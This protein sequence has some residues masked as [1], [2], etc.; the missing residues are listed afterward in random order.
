MV[1]EDAV[2]VY[3]QLIMK[4]IDLLAK[5][6]EEHLRNKQNKPPKRPKIRQGSLS[7]DNFNKLMKKGVDF[8]FIP[9]PKERAWE[10]ARTLEG[11]GGSFFKADDRESANS[12]FAV[13]ANQLEMVQTAVKQTLS[14]LMKEH[15]EAISVKEGVNRIAPEDISLVSDVMRSYDIPLYTFKG[16]DG[17]YTNI[18]PTGSD[19]QYQEA[20]SRVTELKAQLENIDVRTFEMNGLLEMPEYVAKVIPEE[21][22]KDIY[23]VVQ[24]K[25]LDVRFTHNN[26]DTVILYPS[27]QKARVEDAIK[28][29]KQCADEIGKFDIT[30]NDNSISID[31]ETL[32]KGEDEREYFVKVPN[33]HG[34]DYLR[35]DKG[36]VS[37]INSGKTLTTKLEPKALYPIFNSRGDF[38]AQRATFTETSRRS[39]GITTGMQST[40]RRRLMITNTICSSG[41]HTDSCRDD[42]EKRTSYPHMSTWTKHNHICT[43]HSSR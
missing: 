23:A 6:G 12:L 33:T 4:F 14:N 35:L 24:A 32:L 13:P 41:K 38:V 30:V 10:I 2:S 34:M 39:R 29:C 8:K 40:S 18:V 17:M 43:F 3:T 11:L 19:G 7:K 1:G 27:W 36:I 21:E 42:T 26:D 37:E 15:P 25:G 22:S 28:E 20:M 5:L 16:E 31:K 9:I